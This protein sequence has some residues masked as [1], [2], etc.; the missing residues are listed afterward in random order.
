M[1]LSLGYSLSFARA[2]VSVVVAHA[3]E[4]HTLQLSRIKQRPPATDLSGGKASAESLTLR[5]SNLAVA[6]AVDS[7]FDL[8]ACTTVTAY[9]SY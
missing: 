7:Q 9:K 6:D 8:G 5:R 3:G 4:G 1:I 2:S